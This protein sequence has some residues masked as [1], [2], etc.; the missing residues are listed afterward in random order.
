MDIITWVVVGLVAGVW[1]SVVVPGRG[2]G[3][4]GHIVLGVAGAVIGS[5]TAR[6]LGWHGPFPGVAGVAT[7]A[8]VGAVIVLGGLRMLKLSPARP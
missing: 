2:P 5:W 3:V 7:V 8:F 6:A 4:V 1:A